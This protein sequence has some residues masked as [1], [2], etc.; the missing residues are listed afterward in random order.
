MTDDPGVDA[1]LRKLTGH[2]KPIALA[3]ASELNTLGP[4]LSCGLAWGFPCW[5]GNERIF[6]IISHSDRCNL[7]IFYGSKLAEAFPEIIEGTGKQMRHVK[8]RHVC[9]IND[10]LR[11]LIVAGIEMD[12]TDPQ[13]IR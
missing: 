11:R 7:Q 1:Y 9:E 6:S 2:S 8:V 5:S 4:A 3:L 12:A 13:R 10:E